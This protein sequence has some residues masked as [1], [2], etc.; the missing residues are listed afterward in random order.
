M[1][2]V[3]LNKFVSKIVP[4]QHTKRVNMIRK[5]DENVLLTCSNDG[6]VKIWDSRSY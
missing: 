1:E 6:C 3:D 2:L 4:T 5:F